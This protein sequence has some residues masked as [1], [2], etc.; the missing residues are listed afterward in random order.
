MAALGSGDDGSRIRRSRNEGLGADAPSVG[1]SLIVPL[2]VSVVDACQE[3]V[4]DEVGHR[5]AE[6]S[7]FG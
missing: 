6:R 5:A 3:V 4:D 1:A 7:A 2:T